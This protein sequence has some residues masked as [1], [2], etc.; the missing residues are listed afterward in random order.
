MSNLK[1]KTK[2]FL[3]D[4]I[5]ILWIPFSQYCH[6]YPWVLSGVVLYAACNRRVRITKPFCTP[7]WM[8]DWYLRHSTNIVSKKCFSSVKFVSQASVQTWTGLFKLDKIKVM[9]RVKMQKVFCFS[10]RCPSYL[11]HSPFGITRNAD[12]QIAS[13]YPRKC[14]RPLPG[15]FQS[16]KIF[17]IFG[18]KLPASLSTADIITRC[19]KKK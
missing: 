18:P 4:I 3:I 15:T 16:V 19:H 7:H 6:Y 5:G 14:L 13:S 1:L 17:K 2:P 10:L 9:Y 8:E 11:K 12:R